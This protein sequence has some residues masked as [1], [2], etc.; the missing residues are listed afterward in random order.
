M[1]KY[2]VVMT[3][4]GSDSGGGA[5]I[6]ADLKTFAALGAHGTCALTSITS[7]NTTG[8]LDIHDLP[9]PVI[10]SQIRAVASDMDIAHAKTGMLSSSDIILT[11]AEMVREYGIPLVVDPVMAAE[12][13]GSLLQSDA[14]KTLQ[15]KLIPL[16]RKRLGDDIAI[17]GDAN[18]SYDPP[19]AIEVG[20]MLEDIGAVYFEEPCPFDHFEDTK[21]VTDALTIPVAGG[22][23]E[24]SQRRF[25]WM[26]AN[27]GVDIVQPDIMDCGL[28]GG[29]RIT[30]AC[31]VNRVRLVPH[32]W[33]SPIRIASELHW[34]ACIPKLGRA[35]NPPPQLFEL[36]LPHE[37]PAW[38]L[39]P[40][41]IEVDKS[42]G[43][44]AVPTGPGLGI[45]INRDEL[46]RY[47]VDL[48]SI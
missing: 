1:G 5:G 17:H 40:E 33:G 6:Q 16:S 48:I 20:R 19:K 21:K 37:S 38:G 11:V 44:I 28:T 8:V 23:Q 3:I 34:V 43:L 29:K 27:R 35:W 31:A 39:T 15:E 36:H 7:Q 2:P 25:R 9:P 45:E 47:R 24:F 26:I 12:A 22:E 42:D 4:A 30:N 14:V 32:S 13:G 10:A 41:P 18:S 46:E